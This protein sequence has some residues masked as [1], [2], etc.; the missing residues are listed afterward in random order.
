MLKFLYRLLSSLGY[1]SD[2][3]LI[4]IILIL[5][6]ISMHHVAIG[7]FIHPIFQKI[8][9]I[10]SDMLKTIKVC[11]KH[12]QF[13]TK[14]G[15]MTNISVVKTCGGYT[16]SSTRSSVVTTPISTSGTSMVSSSF[17]TTYLTTLLLFL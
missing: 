7:P 8:K 10:F 16:S 3:C 2:I 4:I 17:H 14:L 9:K 11:E 1:Y 6:Q 5:S 13:G 12:A 15:D